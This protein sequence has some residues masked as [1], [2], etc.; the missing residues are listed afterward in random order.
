MISKDIIPFLTDLMRNNNREWF[1]ANKT[2][3]N[4]LRKEW[5]NFINALI[6]ELYNIDKSIGIL[7]PKD[8]TY[9]IYRDIR[10]SND[11]TPFKTHF[12]AFFVRGGKTSGN[13]GYYV[14]IEPNGCFTGGGIHMP[15]GNILKAL[16]TEIFE[17]IDEFKNIIYNKEFFNY[18]GNID[19][20]KLK[21]SPRDFP[22]DFKDIDLLKFKSYTISK[23]LKDKDVIKPE[24]LKDLLYSFKLMSPFIQFLNAAVEHN[25]A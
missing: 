4:K 16:R 1:N 6:P 22:S 23:S 9:R 15:P 24:F 19:A 7:E 2:V 5:E 17:N 8:C 3:Y 21:S 11:K 18:F 10:F 20:E 12:S 25:L 14:H 13:A